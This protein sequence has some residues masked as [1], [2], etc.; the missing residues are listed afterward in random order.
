MHVINEIMLIYI[1]QFQ[2]I[3]GLLQNVALDEKLAVTAGQF[4]SPLFPLKQ[5][6]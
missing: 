2:K 1:G 3:L 4:Q 6:F 5:V